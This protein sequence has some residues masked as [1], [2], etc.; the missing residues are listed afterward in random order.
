MK[1]L[2]F[3]FYLLNIILI[4]LH[5]FITNRGYEITDLFDTLTKNYI[6]RNNCNCTYECALTYNILGNWR[7]Q[8]KLIKSFLNF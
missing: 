2:K 8:P 7:Y 1:K 4:I 5:V 6:L 3:I